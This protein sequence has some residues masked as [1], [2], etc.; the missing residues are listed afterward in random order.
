MF[1]WPRGFSP[2][3]ESQSHVTSNS[4]TMPRN[5]RERSKGKLSQSEKDEEFSQN[6]EDGESSQ[7][8]RER[9]SGSSAKNEDSLQREKRKKIKAN[10]AESGS[11]ES[12]TPIKTKEV[13]NSKRERPKSTEALN[14]NQQE[15]KIK[16][17]A[18]LSDTYVKFAKSL[19][20]GDSTSVDEI[21]KANQE[22]VK[23]ISTALNAY[24]KNALN[25]LRKEDD[26]GIDLG[27]ESKYGRILR[28]SVQ[29]ILDKYGPEIDKVAAVQDD[30]QARDILNLSLIHI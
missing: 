16:L 14:N 8:E 24:V 20:L 17:N 19:L 6:E 21:V 9:K 7:I 18:D 5:K 2:E 27:P 23:N 30:Y 12:V 26:K 22:G 4:R 10:T 15:K 11:E 3:G 28:R 29:A 13:R 25:V 1:R